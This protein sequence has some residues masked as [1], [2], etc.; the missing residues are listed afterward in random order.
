MK[1]LIKKT[2]PLLVI[3]MLLV[4]PIASLAASTATYVTNS[5]GGR[6]ITVTLDSSEGNSFST[7]NTPYSYGFTESSIG[8]PL[9]MSSSGVTVKSSTTLEIVLTAEQVSAANTVGAYLT[10][11]DN[12]DTVV[13]SGIKVSEK[14]IETTNNTVTATETTNALPKTGDNTIVFVSIILVISA[15]S[16]VVYKKLRIA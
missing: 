6:T 11:K 7:S 8:M 16:F 10:V 14:T 3:F 4:L 15:A 1:S 12:D 5:S 2:L 13:V 9:S